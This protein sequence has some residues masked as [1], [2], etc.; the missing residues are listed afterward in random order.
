MTRVMLLALIVTSAMAVSA[1][2]QT[3]AWMN[4][5]LRPSERATLLVAAMTLDEKIEQIAL[6]T[7]P[8]PDLPGCGQRNDTRHIE[9]I[10]RLAVPTIRLT[11]GPIGVAGGDCN[12]NPPTTALPTALSVA[13]SW[14]PQASF[15]WGVIAGQ[16]TRN[17]AHYV[18]LAPGMNLARIGQNG[19]NFEYFGEDPYLSGVMAVR[20]I[21]GV[22]QQGVQASAKHFVA[23]EQETGRQTMNTVVDDRTLHEIYLLPFEMAVKDAA[24]ASIMCSYPRIDGLFACESAPL[25]TEILRKQW[26]FEGWVMSDRGATHSTAA[27]IKAGL[28]LEFNSKATWFT[29]EKIKAALSAGEITVAD[30]DAMLKRRFTTMFRL[31][32]FDM[33]FTAFTPVD[34]KAHA[35]TA[36]TI[37]ERG[38]VLLKNENN[39]LPLSAT[40]LR[41]I[42][43]IGP[44]MFAGAAKLPSTGPRGMITVNAPGTVTP[45]EGLNRVL[46]KLGSKATVVFND[47]KDQA[48]AAALAARSD[49]A[50]VMVG[51][52][53]LE[54]E[55]RVNLSLPTVD[56]VKQEELIAA[57]AAANPRTIVVLKDGGP[58]LMPWLNLTPAVLEAWY[59]GQEDGMAVANLLF[60]VVNPSG[61]LPLSFPK[62]EREGPSAT[63]AQ[64]PGEVRDS[65][66]TTTYAE[67]LRIGY[68]WYDAQGTQP[69]FPFGFGLSYTTF[70]IGKIEVPKKSDGV[71][72][73]KVRFTIENTGKREGAEVAQVYVGLPESA[74]E[75][76]KRLVGFSRVTLAAGAKR[77]VEVVIDANASSH[78]MGYWDGHLKNWVIAPGEYRI[79][80]GNSAASAVLSG[81]VSVSSK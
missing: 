6:N 26:G 5:A 73:I 77:T 18:F 40:S 75:P 59:P 4:P 72:P 48:A 55:D 65:V 49:V 61:K 74:G 78:P 14:D 25:L 19:R 43:L 12:P 62:L 7:G 69:Q 10:P 56:G 76:P 58:I 44:S 50:L 68:R 39:I 51:D 79:Y 34:F 45:M 3:P 1:A 35:E 71:K 80:V 38:S 70:T 57:V 17:I 81:A 66:R 9:G 23:N 8:N 41:S 13:A 60:G 11:N 30:L 20:Q 21:Q 31:G 52:I 2:A 29:P 63:A 37:A 64:W 33:P 36:R 27:A 28:D 24:V 32:Q 42:A 47:G 54:G 22:Q 67:G 46:L 53:S 15:D 16:E